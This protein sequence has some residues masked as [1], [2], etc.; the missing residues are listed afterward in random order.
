[1][2][3]CVR[4]KACSVDCSL[5]VEGHYSE[6]SLPVSPLTHGSD[7]QLTSPYNNLRLSSRQV[8]KILKLTGSK[9]LSWSD[10]KF[11]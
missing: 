1:M 6:C 2:L 8:M 9:L 3:F 4:S 10:T 7:W 11:L 5:L